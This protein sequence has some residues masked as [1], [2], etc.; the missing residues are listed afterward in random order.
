LNEGKNS[1]RGDRVILF[2]NEER[3]VVESN[4]KKQVKAIIYPQEKKKAG[5]N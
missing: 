5:I 3:G 2:I 4:T 1:I